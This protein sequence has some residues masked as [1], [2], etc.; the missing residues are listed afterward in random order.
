VVIKDVPDFAIVVGSPARR[1]G[2]AGR[3]GEPLVPTGEAGIWSCP[4]TN[5]RYR[6]VA[7]DRLEEMEDTE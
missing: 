7:P 4:V 2:W 1:V 5:T 6:E 3:A